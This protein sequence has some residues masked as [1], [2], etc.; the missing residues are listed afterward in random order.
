MLRKIHFLC[1][2]PHRCIV[3]IQMAGMVLRFSV[4]QPL[5]QLSHQGHLTDYAAKILFMVFMNRMWNICLYWKVLVV[6]VVFVV[7][8]LV[9]LSVEPKNVLNWLV[10]LSLKQN[11]CTGNVQRFSY[12]RHESKFDRMFSVWQGMKVSCTH[13]QCAAWAF[14]HLRDHFGCS[15]M[16]TDMAHEYLTFHINVML[17]NAITLA[18]RSSLTS[19][20]RILTRAKHLPPLLLSKKNW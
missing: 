3:W 11:I 6:L 20:Q 5:D 19:L 8:V 1:F 14:E 17:V 2:M 9:L 13:F 15:S 18:L 12:T 10:S 4:F 16:S 7:L